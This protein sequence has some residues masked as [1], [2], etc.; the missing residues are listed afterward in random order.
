MP[1]THL[2]E[3]S[4]LEEARVEIARLQAENKQLRRELEA[5][6]T[7]FIDIADDLDDNNYQAFW[8]D[9]P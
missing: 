5:A 9:T 8:G 3:P 1:I 6:Y 7:A 2:E 4:T